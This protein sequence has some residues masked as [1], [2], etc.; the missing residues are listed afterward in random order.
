MRFVA[1]AFTT[2]GKSKHRTKDATSKAKPPKQEDGE[3]IS[4]SGDRLDWDQFPTSMSRKYYSWYRRMGLNW[5]ILDMRSKS[6]T[7]AGLKRSGRSC[8]LCPKF[9]LRERP[10][11]LWW[12][13]TCKSTGTGYDTRN[14][15]QIHH[16]VGA[17]G[18]A[19]NSGAGGMVKGGAG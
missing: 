16:S 9:H 4:R 11:L 19:K 1:L 2:D 10:V 6:S 3:G 18:S 17:L 7:H 13:Q 15:F 14:W 5:D 12:R 8:R